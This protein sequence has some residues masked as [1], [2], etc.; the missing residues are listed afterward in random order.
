M[1]LQNLNRRKFRTLLT[2][3]MIGITVGAVTVL[4]ALLST[5]KD[6]MGDM[7]G[8]AEI[9]VRDAD[10]PDLGYSSIDERI[11]DRIDAMP[12]VKNV[13]GMIMSVSMNEDTGMFILLGYS[14]HE[15]SI[16]DDF[17]RKFL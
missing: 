14:P 17:G 7:G 4:D 1:A 11:G 13:S 3:G 12:E 8:G 10:T 9:I 2:L 5:M 6:M 15:A 16:Y